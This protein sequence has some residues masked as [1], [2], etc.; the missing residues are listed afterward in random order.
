MANDYLKDE[1]Q[2]P[3]YCGFLV[4]TYACNQD[5]VWCYAKQE[6][7]RARKAIREESASEYASKYFMNL[8]AAKQSLDLMKGI[9]IRRVGLIGGE[10]GLHP[11]LLEII[12]YARRS[13]IKISFYTNG[14][15]LANRNFTAA[16]KEAGTDTVNISVQSGPRE[17]EV[18]NTTVRAKAW[19]QTDEGI[20]LAKKLGMKTII[21]TVITHE[22]SPR[23]KDILDHY[24]NT[25]STF[26]FYREV[27]IFYPDATCLNQ[28]ILGNRATKRAYK[29]IYS[30]AKPLGIKTYLFSRMPLCWWDPQDVVEREIRKQVVSHCHILT[31]LNL[32]VDVNGKVLPCVQWMKQH[33]LDLFPE[34]KILG[35]DQ[36]TRE[37]RNGKPSEFRRTLTYYPSKNCT[38]CPEFGKSCTGGCPLIPFELGPFAP[39]LP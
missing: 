29:E 30:Y 23:Y 4:L 28:K 25:N 16:L 17:A 1:G 13:G 9:G 8:D 11:K 12:R 34:G 32:I 36:F 31:G 20:W 21:Q 10:A 26:I 35:K 38:I 6:V 14:R 5:C 22:V 7:A 37:W 27:P 15:I 2:F 33:I 19:K 39:K 3:F 18:H 24:S